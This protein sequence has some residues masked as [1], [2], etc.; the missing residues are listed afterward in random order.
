[1]KNIE[2]TGDQLC[3]LYSIKARLWEE[4][5]YLW[6]NAK[7]RWFFKKRRR[8]KLFSKV[9]HRMLFDLYEAVN[10]IIE[11]KMMTYDREEYISNFASA[12][13]LAHIERA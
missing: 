9:Y 1:L 6:S 7:F 11:D 4:A 5:E 10:E 8:T 12:K 2:L 3:K 13:D